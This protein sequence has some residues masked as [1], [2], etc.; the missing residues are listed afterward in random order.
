MRRTKAEAEE[1]RQQIICAAERVFF[2]KGVSNA[3]MEDV[4]H[5]A[6]VTRGAIYWH[7]ANKTDLFM[8]LYNSAPL[9]E[10]DLLENWM[11]AENADI[12]AL[13]EKTVGEWLDLI[14][15]DARRQRMFAIILRCD[16]S[17]DLA[18]ALEKQ[19][20][21]DGKYLLF[22]ERAFAHA[23]ATGRLSAHWTPNSATAALRW[24]IKGVCTEWLLFGRRFDLAE[25]GKES[26]R[27]LFL[28]F[29][30]P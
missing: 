14:S 21:V 26:L 20:E 28:S 4:A 16:Y 19:R 8:E 5:A 29:Q 24:M 13:L 27:R 23:D 3:T 10:E 7:F 1:T 15:T 18:A 25:Q 22:L 30:A 2:E 11:R 9:P 17:G 12:L 6:G